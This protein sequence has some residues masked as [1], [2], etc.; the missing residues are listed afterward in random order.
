MARV[1]VAPLVR[2]AKIGAVVCAMSARAVGVA[3][4]SAD[5]SRAAAE[6]ALARR[7][8]DEATAA[9]QRLADRSPNEPRAWLLLGRSLAARPEPSRDDLLRAVRA[10]REATRLAPADPDGWDWLGRAAV[11]LG[12]ADGE[13]IGADALQHLFAL[14]PLRSGAWDNWLLLYRGRGDRQRMRRILSG[15]DTLPEVRA[16]VAYLLIEDGLYDSSA[17]LVGQLLALDPANPEWLALRAQ[18]AYEAGD[19]EAGWRFYQEAL[20]HADRDAA[21]LWRQAVGIASPEEIEA[22]PATAPGDMARFLKSF[23]AGRNPDAFRSSNVRIAEHFAR[24]RDARRQ[25]P[26]LHPLNPYNLSAGG[27]ALEGAPSIAEQMFYDRCEA[28]TT[29]GGP[30]RAS[31]VARTLAESRFGG[32]LF[33][34]LA[35]SDNRAHGCPPGGCFGIEPAGTLFLD[36]QFTRLVSIPHTRDLRDADTTA[37]RIGYNLA[38]G[39]DDR[40]LMLLRFGEPVRR[41][42]GSDNDQDQFCRIPDLERWVYDDIGT[43]RFMRPSAVYVGSRG[44]VRQTGDVLLRPMNDAQFEATALG[45]TRDATSVPATLAFGFWTAQLASDVEGQ[46]DLV[47]VTTRGAV[48]ASVVGAGAPAGVMERGAQGITT[49]SAP[50]GSYTLLVHARVADSLGR[51]SAGVQLRGFRG[52]SASDLLLAPAWQGSEPTRQDMMDRL[53]RDL[54]FAEGTVLRAYAELYGGWAGTSVR[55][56]AIYQVVRTDDAARDVRRDSLPGAVTLE[57]TRERPVPAGRMLVEWLDI[58]PERLPRGSY[59]LRLDT[60]DESGRRIGRSQ[61]AFQIR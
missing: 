16:R 18:C 35:T 38:T 59:L 21:M 40:G 11:R 46:A 14:D 30:T 51:Q 34:P 9:A 13:R 6:S 12:G 15:H 8:Y 50:A 60:R 4:Q 20:A 22:W 36:P 24:L 32:W 3:G 49:L 2:A 53:P 23:W 56:R 54:A 10:L 44:G 39:L 37:A 42:I 55:Y 5:A 7:E 47:V 33:N 28:R 45:L 27:R 29:I 52:T 61:I 26:L 48:A 17:A 41:I 43:M 31:D 1:S 19:V 58:T 25:F 57:F